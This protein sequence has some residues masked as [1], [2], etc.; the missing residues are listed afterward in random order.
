VRTIKARVKKEGI[1]TSHFTGK[2]WSKNKK[3]PEISFPTYTLEEILVD[4][5]TY[6]NNTSL[7]KRLIDANLLEDKC[8][9]C[10]LGTTWCDKP[11][12]LQ[13]DHINGKH[14]L[15]QKNIKTGKLKDRIKK[16]LY[17][18]LPKM[19]IVLPDE[20][21]VYQIMRYVSG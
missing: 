2:G 12:V 10:H 11:L 18:I 7:K 4:D 21:M 16:N 1:D 14:T 6:T 5:S 20:N 15:I 19:D 3:R 9:I 17:Y 13:L 8:I